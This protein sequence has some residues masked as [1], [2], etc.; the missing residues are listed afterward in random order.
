[1]KALVTGATGFIGS[2]LARRLIE[3]NWNVH[4]LKR[5]TSS[6]L[7]LE[8]CVDSLQ[9]HDLDGID[10]ESLWRT[11]GKV[12]VVFH[13]ATAYGR[14]GQSD[15]QVHQTNVLIPGQLLTQAGEFAPLCIAADT[16][17]PVTYPYLQA[18]TGSKKQFASWGKQW[19][20][21]T[22]S[23]FVNLVLQHPFGPSDGEG[24]FVPWLIGQCLGNVDAID[25]TT[26][27]QKKD[28]IYVADVVD[29]MVAI[30]EQQD[31][32]PSQFSELPCGRGDATTV[33][34]FV[35]RIHEVSQ[36][37]SKL[38][39]GAVPDREGEPP[40]S[41]ADTTAINALGWTPRTSLDDGIRLTV[42]WHRKNR[43]LC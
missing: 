1:M 19:A 17:F 40:E 32:L 34:S 2:H 35:E 33:R 14:D 39:F 18:Y 25:L 43:T 15:E 6:L 5:E 4:V 38:N 42:D 20:A 21:E 26:G 24:K 23:R 3:L 12:D 10:F 29:A 31:E 37:S 8:G 27:L 30:A 36:S 41:Y 7:R 16:C 28:F 22:G 11:I 9:L 13:L